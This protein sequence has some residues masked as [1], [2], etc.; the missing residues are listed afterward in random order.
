MQSYP[1]YLCIFIPTIPPLLPFLTSN[2]P[3]SCTHL[4]RPSSLSD[5]R[6]SRPTVTIDQSI[7]SKSHIIP[8]NTIPKCPL[9][10]VLGKLS[11]RRQNRDIEVWRLSLGTG[12]RRA[13]CCR[14]GEHHSRRRRISHGADS[15]FDGCFLLS[16]EVGGYLGDG[17]LGNPL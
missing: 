17:Y 12:W 8:H 5:P 14:G 11:N 6:H 10:Q 7:F 13:A 2:N 9:L 4:D 15:V 1:V 3:A 16:R